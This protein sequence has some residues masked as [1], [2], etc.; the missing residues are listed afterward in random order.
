MNPETPKVQYVLCVQMQ[1]INYGTFDS[2]TWDWHSLMHSF[3]DSRCQHTYSIS[4]V[5]WI[6]IETESKYFNAPVDVA[7]V[8]TMV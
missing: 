3:R 6:Y 4:M 8:H 5:E 2:F 1:E 7:F